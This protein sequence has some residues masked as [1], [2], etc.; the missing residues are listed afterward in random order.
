[1]GMK[2]RPKSAVRPMLQSDVLFWSMTDLPF[3]VRNAVVRDAGQMADEIDISRWDPDSSKIDQKITAA[4]K[5]HA[6][7]P[8]EDALFERYAVVGWDYH[9]RS[10]LQELFHHAFCEQLQKRLGISPE[11]VEVLVRYGDDPS[12]PGGGK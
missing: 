5:K 4:A 8:F 1:M 3:E 2:P 9:R 12:S 11:K 7:K 10:D 6:A